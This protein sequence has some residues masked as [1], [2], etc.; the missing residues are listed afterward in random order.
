MLI[1]K[2]LDYIN[3]IEA[4]YDLIS[5]IETKIAKQEEFIGNNKQL[6][7]LRAQSLLMHALIDAIQYDDNERPITNETFLLCLRKL[8]N[9]NIC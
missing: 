6:D 9:T 4:G 1:R 2:D 5:R 8:I 7:K 3:E